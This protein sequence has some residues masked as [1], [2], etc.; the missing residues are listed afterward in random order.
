MKTLKVLGIHGLGDH[1]GT[2]WQADWEAALRAA[3]PGQGQIDLDIKFLTYDDI[4]EKV[5]LTV[6]ETMQAFW[7]LS[8]S[9]ISSLFRRRRGMI[10]D[11]SDR[12]RWTAG[13]VVAWV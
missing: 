2:T 5:D 4:F 13:Y 9:G 8:R 12:I 7:K 10:G 1:R 6:W 3:F 11:V